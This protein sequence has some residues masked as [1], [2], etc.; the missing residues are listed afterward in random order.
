MEN[1]ISQQ[2]NPLSKYFRQ[3]SIYMKLPSDGAYWPEG[4][5]DL[6]VTGEVA[7]YP[8]TTRDEVTLRTPDALMNGSGVV[9]VIQSCCPSIKD[10]WKMPNID[11]DA[12]LIA[13]RIA[14]YG[15]N[16]EVETRCPHCQQSNNHGLDLQNC[17]SSIRSPDYKKQIP[18]EQ[19][20]IRLKPMTYFGQNRGNSIEF[21]E[22]KMLQALERADINDEARAAQIYNSMQRLIQI[23]IETL[24]A[25]TAA[26]TLDDGTVVSDQTF[27]ADFYANSASAI[28][29]EIQSKLTEINKDA[30]IKPQQVTCGECTKPY[31]VPVIFDYASFF[32]SGS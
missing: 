20:Q 3:P 14:S 8:M 13:I 18:V 32:G 23:N 6:P 27:I 19:L 2:V 17:L 26:I 10:A 11:V 7:V 1:N 29:K 15:T 12:V 5:L 30:G 24:A 4:T 22:Q 9:D 25:S 21:E 28:V 31:Q 16:M